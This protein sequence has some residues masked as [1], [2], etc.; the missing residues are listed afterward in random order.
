MMKPA[1]VKQRIH[2]HMASIDREEKR[3][4]KAKD[5]KDEWTE[6]EARM[7]LRELRARV[8]ECELFLAG[9]GG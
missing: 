1:N 2:T 9:R 3:L 5:A 6:K 7:Q 8:D 4:Q